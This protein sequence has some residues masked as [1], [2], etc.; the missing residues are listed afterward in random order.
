VEIEVDGGINEK[1]IAQVAGAGATV[2]VSGS[3]VFGHPQGYQAAIK[4]MRQAA[5]Q[6]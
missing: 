3:G 2:F 4:A 1:T 5:G 6:T